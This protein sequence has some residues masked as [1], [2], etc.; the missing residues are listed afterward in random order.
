MG[1][2]NIYVNHFITIFKA[3]SILYYPSEKGSDLGNL[4]VQFPPFIDKE[5]DPEKLSNTAKV[6]QVP[7]STVRTGS[8]VS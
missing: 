3:L 5:I 8:Q 1:R 7:G 2:D 6:K 4:L